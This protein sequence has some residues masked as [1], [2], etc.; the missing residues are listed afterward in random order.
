MMELATIMQNG[1]REFSGRFRK[2]GLREPASRYSCYDFAIGCAGFQIQQVVKFIHSKNGGDFSA[3]SRIK[4]LKSE[5]YQDAKG[6]L[7]KGDVIFYLDDQSRLVHAAI[8]ADDRGTVYSKFGNEN[9]YYYEH[10]FDDTPIEY[11][12]KYRILRKAM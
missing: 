7:Q 6:P 3:D 5:G 8:A 9:P 1:Y 4:F 11:G 12:T 10:R 2:H